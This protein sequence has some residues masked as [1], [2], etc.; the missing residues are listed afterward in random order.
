MKIN[1][2]Y[3]PKEIDNL[4]KYWISSGAEDENSK[5]RIYDVYEIIDNVMKKYGFDSIGEGAYATVYS[6]PEYPYV[7]KVFFKDSAYL[8]WL[9]FCRMH[10][11]NKYI[12]KIKG[13]PIRIIND[14]W[15][16]RL[17]HLSSID[18]TPGGEQTYNEF[19]ESFSKYK[20]TP[21]NEMDDDLSVVFEFLYSHGSKLDMHEENI[22]F[23]KKQLV[24]VDPM[25]DT[26][27]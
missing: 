4:R 13:K 18:N 15:A 8:K 21:E 14:L 23:R 17:E 6:N 24:I 9:S 19:M 27:G 7:L 22:M 10:Q 2:L 1:E 5:E 20:T 12:P 16:V 3:K 11:N 25:A 26:M